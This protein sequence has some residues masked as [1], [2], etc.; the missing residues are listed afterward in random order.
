MR[1][2]RF[3]IG[4]GQIQFDNLALTHGLDSFET[5]RAQRATDGFALRV[6]NAGF[7]GYIYLGFH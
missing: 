1:L 7:E 3:R 2:C 6:E 5:Q 4:F